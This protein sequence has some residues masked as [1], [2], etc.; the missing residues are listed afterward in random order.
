MTTTTVSYI[1]KSSTHQ[2]VGA[3]KGILSKG[4]AYARKLNLDDSVLLSDDDIKRLIDAY[5]DMVGFDFV[6]QHLARLG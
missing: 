6:G 3:L 1:L 2:T 5:S 4:E